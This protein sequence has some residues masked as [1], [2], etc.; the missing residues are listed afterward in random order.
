MWYARIATAYARP[1]GETMPKQMMVYGA[2][3][4]VGASGCPECDCKRLYM[5]YVGAYTQHY[6]HC[7]RVQKERLPSYRIFKC[8]VPGVCPNEM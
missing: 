7:S 4:Y 5:T 8:D 1:D 2:D 3:D 6:D